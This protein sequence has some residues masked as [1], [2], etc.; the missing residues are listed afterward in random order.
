MG[1]PISLDCWCVCLC[2]LH[3][4][5]ENP[6]DGE[7]YLLVP[8]RPGCPGQ[9]PN[10]CKMVVC[11]CVC[12]WLCVCF[13]YPVSLLYC[14][15]RL[16]TIG[17]ILLNHIFYATIWLVW[18]LRSWRTRNSHLKPYCLWKINVSPLHGAWNRMFKWELNLTSMCIRRND[19]ISAFTRFSSSIFALN[20]CKILKQDTS[21]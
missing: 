6:E 15:W 8:A 10:S 11:V 18:Q 2:Y 16:L 9:S 5:P 20:S 1:A 17:I 3:F 14:T 21:S 4:A 7:M 13:M 12:V 19:S